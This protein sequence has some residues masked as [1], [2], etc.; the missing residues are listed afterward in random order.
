VSGDLVAFIER[1]DTEYFKSLQCT[2]PHTK[3][4]VERLRD[5]P[6][7]MVATQNIQFY[8]EKVGNFRAAAKVAPRQVELIYYKPEEAYRVFS[9]N[10]V[11]TYPYPIPI[12]VSVS[13]LHRMDVAGQLHLL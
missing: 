12:H 1:L 11:S 5:E 3:D 4:Y 6:L 2:D 13:V 8:L 10:A 9:E 7:F